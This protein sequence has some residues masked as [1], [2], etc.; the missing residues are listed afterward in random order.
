MDPMPEPSEPDIALIGRIAAVPTILEVICASTGMGVAAVS[1]VTE[2]R[3]VACEVRD[4]IGFGLRRGT[5]LKIETTFCDQI[6]RHGQPVVIEHVA[7]DADYRSHAIPAMYKFQSYISLPIM[8]PDGRFF[9]TLCAIDVAPRRLKTPAILGMFRLFAEMIGFHID[10]QQRLAVSEAELGEER[11]DARLREQFIAV[12]GHD[13]RNPLASIDACMR[14]LR[15]GGPDRR[16]LDVIEVAEASVRRMAGLIG[17]VLDLARGRL[18]D[19]IP[20]AR[21]TGRNLEP[22]LRQVVQET[23]T[24]HPDRAI[25]VELDLREPVAC[26]AGR[27]AQLCSNLLGNAVSHGAPDRPVGL[28]AASGEGT[29]SLLVRNGGEPIP[30]V[31]LGRLFQPFFRAS[32]RPGQEGLGLGLYIAAEIARA[33]GG[34]LDVASDAAETC[35]TFR[36]PLAAA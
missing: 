31:A 8:L 2:A 35:F 6:R 23:M 32:V 3:W 19:G 10:A 9:G 14:V 18:G 11:A 36:M 12:L 21:E 1:R 34:T 20:L 5:E 28:V 24:T 33:H 30:E 7:E 25:E 17:D 22:M 4:M 29:F 16:S 15:K 27:I 26:D 13:L